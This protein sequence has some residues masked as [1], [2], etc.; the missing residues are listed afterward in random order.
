MKQVAKWHLLAIAFIALVSSVA[1]AAHFSG[2]ISGTV[3]DA[4]GKPLVEASV[5]VHE[6]TLTDKVLQ[7]TKTDKNGRFIAANLLSGRYTLIAKASGYKSELLA[8]EVSPNLSPVSYL[9]FK[10]KRASDLLSTEEDMN[11]YKYV[12]RRNR[13]ILHLR[14]IPD[15]VQSAEKKAF[16]PETH[17]WVSF[18]TS[19]SLSDRVGSGTFANFNFAVS[20]MVSEDLEFTVSGQTGTG[21]TST[22]RLDT[23]AVV[24]VDDNHQVSVSLGYSQIPTT[25]T[26]RRNSLNQYNLRA[27]DRWHIAG[28]IVIVYGFDY[29]RLDG[30]INAQNIS[31]RIN[32]D[33][34]V[35]PQDQIFAAIYAPEGAEIERSTEFET[36][37]V[38][39]YGPVEF[40][41]LDSKGE[42]ARR[43]EVGHVHTFQN[44]TK[45]ETALFWDQFSAQPQNF[46]N[47]SN[48]LD[49]PE[50]TNNQENFITRNSQQAETHGLRVVVNRPIS[51]NVSTS[52]G[53]AVG[54]GQQIETSAEGQPT[55][56]YGY[57]Q[58]VSGKVDAQII[59]TGTR[60]SAV[61]RIASPNALLAIDPFQGR[62]RSLDPSIS[63]YLTQAVPMFSFVPGRWEAMFDARNILDSGKD[64]RVIVGQYW[65]AI[66]GGLSVRF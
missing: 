20:Q 11:S 22:N 25:F 34:Q 50:T 17:G 15:P 51:K 54:R 33:M 2:S 39:F 43:Y 8:A 61:L 23:Q 41:S 59:S 30:L 29:S 14:D 48:I 62:L 21:D 6:G 1:Q 63:I 52:L 37:N 44:R 12:Y 26:G 27:T 24:D 38:N 28:P 13:S 56:S 31:P 60:I 45:V 7:T 66:R 19:Q 4:E 10:L 35:T 53:Y 65:R 47:I 58:V 16:I 42:R 3:K 32:F 55:L 36:T 64:E 18:T 49:L 5:V 9:S 57:F 40:I 46:L